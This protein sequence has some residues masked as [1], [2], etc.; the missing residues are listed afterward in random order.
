MDKEAGL[1]TDT[2]AQT[3]HYAYKHNHTYRYRQA[4]ARQTQK[5]RQTDIKIDRE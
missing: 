5:H 1:L 2:V 4:K 3:S